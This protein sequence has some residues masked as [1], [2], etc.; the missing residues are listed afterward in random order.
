VDDKEGQ[1]LPAGLTVG[2]VSLTYTVELTPG[3]RSSNILTWNAPPLSLQEGQSVTLTLNCSTGHTPQITAGWFIDCV[4]GDNKRNVGFVASGPGDS[5]TSTTT[6]SFLPYMRNYRT[7]IA[8]EAGRFGNN[9]AT[10][11]VWWKYERQDSGTIP[12]TIKDVTPK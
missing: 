6:F 9:N 10:L 8:L 1:P 5:R 7:F 3:Q 12:T 4:N 11:S 2:D